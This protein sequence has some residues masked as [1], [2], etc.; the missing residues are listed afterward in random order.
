M[1]DH[2][3]NAPDTKEFAKYLQSF[4]KRKEAQHQ[5]KVAKAA[6]TSLSLMI[7]V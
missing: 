5:V 3:K 7:T 6:V 4:I 2:L 1:P